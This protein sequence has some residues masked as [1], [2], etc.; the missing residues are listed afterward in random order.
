MLRQEMIL[1]D[2]TETLMASIEMVQT[3]DIRNKSNVHKIQSLER[4]KSNEIDSPTKFN[5]KYEC[6]YN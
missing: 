4:D 2:C 3:F 6:N 1:H 5:C